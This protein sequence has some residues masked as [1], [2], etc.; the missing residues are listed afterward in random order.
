MTFRLLSRTS[1][2]LLLLSFVFTSFT[3]LAQDT[4]PHRPLP[5]P[6]TGSRG[7]EQGSRDASSRLIAA[8]A[9]RGPLKP[10]APYEG[11]A[12]DARPFFTWT[13]AQGAA[14]YHF[15]LR[16]G[17]DSSAPIVYEAD[18]KTAQLS[19]SADAPALTPGSI[20]S[21]RIS[22]A[23]VLERR[24]GPIATFFVL[25]GEDARQIKTA[26]EKTKLTTPKNAAER[27]AQ[28]RIFEEY[29]VWYDALRIAA[30][31]V[32]ADANNADAK[33][34]YNA[35]IKKLTDETEKAA[36][37]TSSAFPLWQQL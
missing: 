19:Y 30:E 16:A 23:G 15:T 10:T 26:L 24:Q 21:W 18:A 20:Y 36:A 6:P 28:A 32:A 14:S 34:Y 17:A 11:L 12:Y 37:Q 29:G 8:G 2:C 5:K 33:A 13:P 3:A 1:V 4:K 27:L 7:F 25:T 9:T 35:L 22:T 31:L